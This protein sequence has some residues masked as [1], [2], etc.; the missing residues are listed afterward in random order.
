MLTYSLWQTVT[1]WHHTDLPGNIA[2]SQQKFNLVAT[3]TYLRLISEGTGGHR[4][5]NNR[6]ASINAQKMYKRCSGKCTLYCHCHT[7]IT[8]YFLISGDFWDIK[9]M[10]EQWIPGSRSPPT[11]SLDT[12]PEG[13]M[14]ETIEADIIFSAQIIFSVQCTVWCNQKC[15]IGFN[16][17]KIVRNR[18]RGVCTRWLTIWAN[19]P[20]PLWEPMVFVFEQCLYYVCLVP[21]WCHSCVKCSHAFP[22]FAGI[23]LPLICKH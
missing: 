12:R 14:H 3:C 2:I 9:H 16:G 18:G 13:C 10:R 8:H 17:W 21:T 6:N 15:T 22:V 11:E 7:D 5:T 23:T 1:Q 19:T 4:I 20:S